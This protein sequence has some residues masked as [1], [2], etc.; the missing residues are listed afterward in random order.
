MLRRLRKQRVIA[1]EQTSL[2]NGAPRFQTRVQAT[3]PRRI[4]RERLLSLG[5]DRFRQHDITWTKL[6]IQSAGYAEA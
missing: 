6:F 3:P 1:T 4:R 5:D 2:S